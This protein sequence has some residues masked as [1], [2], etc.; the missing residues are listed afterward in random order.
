MLW[1]VMVQN[2]S[3]ITR[4]ATWDA[5]WKKKFSM[6]VLCHKTRIKKTY[7]IYSRV[8]EREETSLY[9]LV[10]LLIGCV[11]NCLQVTLY[12]NFNIRN[13]MIRFT[14]STNLF[15]FS[16]EYFSTRIFKS[17]NNRLSAKNPT[18]WTTFKT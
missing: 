16:F 3:D 9:T 2:R 11:W 8:Y 7:K 6:H 10:Y 18:F 5:R 17:T 1:Q 12:A 4:D 14:F 15:I 13:N